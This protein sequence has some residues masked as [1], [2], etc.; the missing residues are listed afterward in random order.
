MTEK[1]EDTVLQYVRVNAGSLGQCTRVKE[2]M[3]G[4]GEIKHDGRGMWGSMHE[5]V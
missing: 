3:H 5:K 1:V 4:G 2:K